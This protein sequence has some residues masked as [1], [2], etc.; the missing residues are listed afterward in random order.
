MKDPTT[1]DIRPNKY[2]LV[3]LDTK[4]IANKNNTI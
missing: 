1:A 2:P 3:N 4:N